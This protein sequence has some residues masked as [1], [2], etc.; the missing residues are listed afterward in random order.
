MME[1]TLGAV[2]QGDGRCRFRVWAPRAKQVEVHLLGATD[3]FVEMS[4]R[5][6]GYWQV[7]ADGVA[8]GTRYRYRL[9]GQ[10]ELPDPAS[11]SQPEGV[12]GPSQV[13]DPG[14]PWKDSA[15]PGLVLDDYVIY[16]IHVGAYTP[17]GTFDAILPHLPELQDLGVTAIEMMPVAQFPGERNWGYDGTYPFAVQNSY[18]GP[19]GLK[20]L[21]DACH[22]AGIAVVLDVVYNHLGPEGNYLFE[23][24]PY[25]SRRYKPTWGDALNFDGP[26]SDEVRQFFIE[27][28]FH[29]LRDYHVDA[30]RLDAVHGI[31][32]F[33]ARTFLQELAG[34][35]HDLGKQMNRRVYLIPESDLN[36]ARLVL[37]PEIGG[38]GLDAQWNDDFHHALHTLLTGER[39]GYYRDFGELSYLARAFRE[40]FVYSGQRS[41]Y[42]NRRHGSSSRLVRADQ[43]VVFIQ[44]HDQVGNRM[45]GER[46]GRL[47]EEARLRLAAAA[48]ILSPY[49]PLLFMGEE[50]NETA[51]F[52][53]FIQHGDP[54]LI[55]S[56][57]KGRQQEF[58]A[59]EWEQ[60]LPDPQA[61]ETF[62]GAK[63]HHELKEQEPNAALRRFYKELLRVRK[64]IPALSHLSKDDMDVLGLEGEKLL[65]VHRW[66]ERSQVY[67]LF[68][69]SNRAER[70]TIPGFGGTWERIVDSEDRRWG[71]SGSGSPETLDLRSSLP[72]ELP[73]LSCL[74]YASRA[75][76][77]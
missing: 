63:L 61:N 60:E 29:W 33:S 65:V 5:P 64:E 41:T 70:V 18:G 66:K 76:R 72:I 27:N 10:R 12:H 53:Y 55:E 59:F 31:Y 77:L 54:G 69:F 42:R 16:E 24:G 74:A 36:D 38:F 21:V 44:N 73:P 57:R 75:W 19:Q 17:Q 30:L 50:W 13:L 49:L 3:R 56:V 8:P 68:N 20:R 62:E 43:M 48:V 6:S 4:P 22:R 11:I 23:Y 47:V 58:A 67:L 37:R 15:W 71:G 40:G 9:D 25:N 14:F 52:P 46:I 45:R 35:V 39:M 2:Y 34:D 7:T 1:R 28:A 26:G 32:D 51:S